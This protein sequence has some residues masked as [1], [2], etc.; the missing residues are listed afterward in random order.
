[1]SEQKENT[2]WKT[3]LRLMP[4]V[5]PHRIWLV[6][7]M[8]GSTLR[9]FSSFANT[10]VLQQL[11]DTV[12]RTDTDSFVK[13][14]YI[15]G[16][17]VVLSMIVNYGTRYASGR[18]I[19]P[20]LRD[21]RHRTSEHIQHLPM[22]NL[23]AHHTGDLIS[24]LNNDI[25]QIPALLNSISE[26]VYQP[27]LFAGSFIYL[28]LISWKLLVI[29]CILIPI[30][31][32]LYNKVS[33]PMEELSR[34]NLEGHSRANSMI[35]DVIGGMPIVKAFNLQK[36]MFGRYRNVVQEIETQGLAMDRRE[37]ALM[38]LYLALRYIPQLI[39]PLYGGYLA[40]K[41]EISPGSVVAANLLI[42]NVFQ[43][44]EALLGLLRQV[45]TI[46]PAIQRVFEILDEVPEHG[47][48]PVVMSDPN[49]PP[50]ELGEL[51]F[52]YDGET[53]IL[54][55]LSLEVTAGKMV[56]LVGA[57]GSGKSTILKLIC[58]FYQPSAGYI[59][60]YGQD[61]AASDLAAARHHMSLVSQDT[62]L[63][64]TTIAENIAYGRLGATS[65]DI[66]AAAQQ[67]NAHDFIMDFPE[68][69]DTDIGER[70]VKLSGG[71]RQ[72][73]ALARA[74][75]KDAPILLLDEPTS[76]LD[77][78]SEFLVQQALERFM[79]NRT[80]LVV[81]HRLSTIHNADEILVI[82]QGSVRERGTHEQ[83]MK[84][85]SLYRHL[86][87]RQIVSPEADVKQDTAQE[88]AHD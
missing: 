81:A 35:Q 4:F 6:L 85:E 44:V 84:T 8:L 71:Q 41:G 9:A 15:A 79:S 80:V 73:L 7:N 78:Q 52:S 87:L 50:V 25:G 54:N 56:A 40:L 49:I 47:G 18:T 42:W 67:A 69:Y 36:I 32:V 37:A 17:I 22:S 83:L 64:P 5:K 1:M 11:T 10:L 13:W 23:E 3:V 2:S 16:G 51:S 30:T 46:T 43:P 76:A 60:L 45:R 57:S 12:V 19:S 27:V 61:L 70:G 88:V 58:G 48:A 68:T 14:L 55:Q 63:F 82:E 66:V 20:T 77:T 29:S 31:A 26:V 28:L 72:R 53:N 24:R 62:Y 75:L 65:D 38:T 39:V 34:R 59:R 33:K 74:I 21:L 86:Y